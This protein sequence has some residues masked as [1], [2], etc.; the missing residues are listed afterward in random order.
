MSSRGRRPSHAPPLGDPWF[1][2]REWGSLLGSGWSFSQ[3]A[4]VAR[5]HMTDCARCC[6]RAGRVWREG[7]TLQF[8]P[9]CRLR[10]KIGT[11][12]LAAA[13]SCR[14]AR[15]GDCKRQL[16]TCCAHAA[17]HIDLVSRPCVFECGVESQ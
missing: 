2:D 3:W 11:L 6:S 5:L 4:L 17:H 14:L 1:A 12:A 9:I 16:R 7:W 15:F 13:D 8:T 10:T